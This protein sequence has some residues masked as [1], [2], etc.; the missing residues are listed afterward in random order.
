MPDWT[1]RWPG[2]RTL[3]GTFSLRSHMDLCQLISTILIYDVLVFP[4][5]ED[6]EDF[7]RRQANGWQPETLALR[8]MQLGDHALAIP[9]ALSFG[10]ERDRCCS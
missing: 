1:D 5:P 3:W 10:I 4:W 6:H 8:H 2:A 9:W 7:D